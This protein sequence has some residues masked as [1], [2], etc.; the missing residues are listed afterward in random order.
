MSTIEDSQRDLET[1][2]GAGQDICA[3][4][5]EGRRGPPVL[6]QP[7]RCG[8]SKKAVPEDTALRSGVIAHIEGRAQLPW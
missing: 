3:R 1:V 6:G 4:T 7:A 5:A 8:G 2:P